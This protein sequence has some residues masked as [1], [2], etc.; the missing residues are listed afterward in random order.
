MN[1]VNYFPEKREM[2]T[3]LETWSCN[4]HSL[5]I[6]RLYVIAQLEYCRFS[7]TIHFSR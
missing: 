7:D 6:L 2:Q 3:D 4:L 5:S 1:F